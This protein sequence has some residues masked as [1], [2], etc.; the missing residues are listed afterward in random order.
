MCGF[1][2]VYHPKRINGYPYA[3]VKEMCDAIAHRGP[4]HF[5]FSEKPEV[6]MGHRRLSIIDLSNHAHQ[7]ME[8]DD[9]LI[10]FNGEIYNYLELR[11]ELINKHGIKFHSNSDTEVI[12]KAYCQWGEAC[13]NRFNGMF[14]FVL[15]DK[16]NKQLFVARDRFGVKP[17]FWTRGQSGE[18]IFASDIRS[19]WSVKNP[20][21]Q[22]DKNSITNCLVNG[23]YV[24]NG[25]ASTDI[26]RFPESHFLKLDHS[27]GIAWQEYWRV[28]TSSKVVLSFNDAVDET[29]TLL[30]DAVKLRMRSDVPVG[31]FLSGGIDSSLVTVEMAQTAANRMHTFSIGVDSAEFDE[32][33]YAKIVA[34]QYDTI[35]HHISLNSDGLDELPRIVNKF[36]DVFGDSSA[37]PSYFV[38]KEAAKEIKVV[39]SGDGADESFGGYVIPYATYLNQYYKNIPFSY[40]SKN[41]WQMY[42]TNFLHKMSFL[43]FLIYLGL[44][45]NQ[46]N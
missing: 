15:W 32:S 13:L 7:P 29:E 4:D 8:D 44:L 21:D 10:A 37:L 1:V 33:A 43:G 35:H 3:Q 6:V 22:I 20:A 9:S 40:L 5:G 41:I 11:S 12:L 34:N 28:S 25:T 45:Q 46:S 17:L 23:F 36:S 42:M 27:G 26:K 14:A 30:R 18:W 2:V 16:E 39:F 19:I 31:S 24:G 38:S